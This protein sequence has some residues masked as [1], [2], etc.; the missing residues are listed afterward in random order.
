LADALPS[1]QR[2]ERLEKARRNVAILDPTCPKLAQGPCLD[3]PT[4]AKMKMDQDRIAAVII[5][6]FAE[7]PAR[8]RHGPSLAVHLVS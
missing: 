1:T 6:A 4:E 2:R 5:T 3:Y 7:I 8:R